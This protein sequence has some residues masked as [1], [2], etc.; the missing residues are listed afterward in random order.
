MYLHM[1]R[2]GQNRTRSP[3][4]TVYLMIFLPKIPYI[5]RIY[6]VLAN[7]THVVI[8]RLLVPTK[9]RRIYAVPLHKALTALVRCLEHIAP[10]NRNYAIP[11]HKAFTALVHSVKQVCTLLSK[12]VLC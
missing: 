12:C 3:Y 1:T 10:V 5:H 11:L 4:M 8:S 6:M 9:V 7:P 2:V